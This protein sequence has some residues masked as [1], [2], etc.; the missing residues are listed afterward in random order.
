MK[1]ITFV[2]KPK[3]TGDAAHTQAKDASPHTVYG[4]Y[5]AINFD[6]LRETEHWQIY[7]RA[8]SSKP[9]AAL[10]KADVP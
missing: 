8:Q 9:Q 1:N 2:M 3:L 5:I 10:R 4:S 7:R 6:L